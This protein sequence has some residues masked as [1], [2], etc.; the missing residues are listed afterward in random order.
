M[1]NPLIC[2]YQPDMDRPKKPEGFPGQ[3]IVVLPRK[4]VARSLDHGLL[5][6]L[7]PTDAGYFP[8]AAGHYMER[9]VGVNEAIFIYCAHGRGWCDL[10]G[11]RHELTAG[12]LL[13]VP[14][15]TPHVYGADEEHPWTISWVHV[16]GANLGLFLNELGVSLEHPVVYLGDDPQLLALFEEVLAV[17]E[18]GY[19]PAQLLYASQALAHLLG[20][21]IWHRQ[22]KWRGAPDPTQKINQSLAYMKQHLEKPLHVSTLAAL[23]NL[24]PSHYTALFKQ[25]TGYAPIDYLI[26]L[27]MHWACQLLDTTNLPVKTVAASLGYGDP[28][29]FSRVFKAVNEV[30]PTEYRLMHKG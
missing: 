5:R 24:S 26:H 22:Q 18:H 13:V 21:M 17:L 10:G 2:A 30:A 29:H 3:R 14:P 6:G 1:D 25:H 11:Q 23:V 4:V 19:A 27:R 9:S 28:L 15:G 12:D 8:K 20:V 7:L 16:T